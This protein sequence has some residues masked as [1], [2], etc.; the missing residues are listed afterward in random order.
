MA[1]DLYLCSLNRLLKF[2]QMLSVQ[3]APHVECSAWTLVVDF[4]FEGKFLKHSLY[5]CFYIVEALC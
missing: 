3:N 5:L 1:Y 2:S 4:Y